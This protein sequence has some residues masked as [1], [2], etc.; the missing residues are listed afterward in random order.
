[1][2]NPVA[3]S[4]APLVERMDRRTEMALG[5][6]PWVEVWP[7]A[8]RAGLPTA[9]NLESLE[10]FMLVRATRPRLPVTRDSPLAGTGASSSGSYP[11][12]HI[13]PARSVSAP[14]ARWS[15]TSHDRQEN[16]YRLHPPGGNPGRG[17]QRNPSGR[18]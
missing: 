6:L 5:W 7:C 1:M 13:R 11:L 17:R 3:R 16:A 8:R 10:V 14:A 9:Q 18:L 2:L 12:A 15:F 4:D